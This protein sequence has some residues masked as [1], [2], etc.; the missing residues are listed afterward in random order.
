MKARCYRNRSLTDHCA[1]DNSDTEHRYDD[2]ICKK[3]DGKH[4]SLVCHFNDTFLGIIRVF[5]RDIKNL[6]G[7]R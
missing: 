2:M 1:I 7:V 3:L 4:V 6:N 5:E